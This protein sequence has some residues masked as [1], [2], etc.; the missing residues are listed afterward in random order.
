MCLPLFDLSAGFSS[1]YFDLD[2]LDEAAVL[3]RGEIVV[4]PR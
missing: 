1:I 3:H 4:W 2:N